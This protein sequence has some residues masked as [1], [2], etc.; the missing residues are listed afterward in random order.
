MLCTPETNKRVL[1]TGRQI[2]VDMHGR[3][4]TFVPVTGSVASDVN[5]VNIVRI[6]QAVML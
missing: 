4:S 3:R 5:K 2:T 6:F 1:N